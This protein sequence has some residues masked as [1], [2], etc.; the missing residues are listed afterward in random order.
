MNKE[1]YKNAQ[2]LTSINIL[3]NTA[4]V[5]D[6]IVAILDGVLEDGIVALKQKSK[7]FFCCCKCSFENVHT[8]KLVDSKVKGKRPEAEFMNLQICRGF[9]T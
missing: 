6:K 4:P 7:H 9:W 8:V 3:F 1:L 2:C 5:V